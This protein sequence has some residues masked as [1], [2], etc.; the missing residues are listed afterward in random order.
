MGSIPGWGK[1]PWRRK[2]QHTLV[3]LPRKLHGQRRLVCYSSRG[4]KQLDTTEQLNWAKLNCQCRRPK[5]C[6][7]HPWVKKISWSRKRQPVPV[8]L[9][10]KLHGQRR[11]AGYSP[12][13]RK[14]LAERLSHHLPSPNSLRFAV[15]YTF[16]E[17]WVSLFK[18]IHCSLIDDGEVLFFGSSYVA[19]K[20]LFGKEGIFKNSFIVKILGAYT[21]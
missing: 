4:H 11:L 20:I 2:W 19:D 10:R 21:R 9:P 18:I 5:R 3:F 17:Y 16:L 1:I 13:G 7:F 15:Q 6:R 12:W 8:F 14:E